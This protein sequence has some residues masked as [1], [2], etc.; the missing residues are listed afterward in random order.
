[1]LSAIFAR[2]YGAGSQGL[3]GRPASPSLDG[4]TTTTFMAILVWKSFVRG[5]GF[6]RCKRIYLDGHSTC[7]CKIEQHNCTAKAD[8]ADREP[9]R[10]CKVRCHIMLPCLCGR[11][12]TSM[13]GQ[14]HIRFQ[15]LDLVVAVWSVRR[16]LLASWPLPWSE[17]PVV[18]AS[19][20]HT[21]AQWSIMTERLAETLQR[22]DGTY[23]VTFWL[24]GR[25]VALICIL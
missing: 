16:D 23:H 21:Q 2:D 20:V 13:R 11:K 22:L 9:V 7:R 24:N 4:R 10:E 25:P 6:S 1:M 5:W 19:S 18:Q 12:L 8:S 17:K 3:V 15:G 14:S